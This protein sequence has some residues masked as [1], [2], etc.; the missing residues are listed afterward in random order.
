MLFLLLVYNVWY[1]VSFNFNVMFFVISGSVKV[2]FI[3]L[4]NIGAIASQTFVNCNLIP[5]T[6]SIVVFLW[7]W[8]GFLYLFFSNASLSLL[9]CLQLLHSVFDNLCEFTSLLL[10]S[11][12]K[13]RATVLPIPANISLNLVPLGRFNGSELNPGANGKKTRPM[14]PPPSNQ[15]M[16]PQL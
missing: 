9:L 1:S 3:K 6:F 4:L 16:L 10:R 11:F 15:R 13:G 14:A 12:R 7:G 8:F 5:W 2:V